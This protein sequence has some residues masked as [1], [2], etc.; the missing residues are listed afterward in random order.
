MAKDPK[1]KRSSQKKG[2]EFAE[3]YQDDVEFDE[4]D[5]VE[6]EDAELLD[7][8]DVTEWDDEDDT[9]FEQSRSRQKDRRED[10]PPPTSKIGKLRERMRPHPVRPGEQDPLQSPL[11]LGLFGGTLLLLLVG[12]ILWFIIGRQSSQKA[13]DAAQEKLDTGQYAQ[14]IQ[15]FE[16]FQNDYPTH[17]LLPQARISQ[18]KA[19]LL[20]YITGGSPDWPKGLEELQN[21]IRNFKDQEEFDELK[22]DLRRYAT[23]IAVGSA[24]TA[25]QARERS[26]LTIP[27]QALVIAQRYT[28]EEAEADELEEEIDRLLIVANA[29][30]VKQETYDAA[31]AKIEKALSETP[32]RTL[33]GMHTREGLLARYPD[34]ETNPKIRLLLRQTLNAEKALVKSEQRDLAVTEED[35]PKLPQPPVTLITHSSTRSDVA[36]RNNTIF[37]LAKGCLFGADA[38]TG[39]PVWRR[40][41]GLDTPFF[42]QRI[43]TKSPG[44]LIFDTNYR[45]L[46]ALSER[47]GGLLWRLP[48]NDQLTGAPLEH[49]NFLYF[50]STTN[51]LYKIDLETGSPVGVLRFSQ[52][53]LAPALPAPDGNH[54]IAVGNQEMVYTIDARNFECVT[55]SHVGH[56]RGT[57]TVDAPLIDMGSLILLPENDR[58]DSCLL[59]V[60]RMGEPEEQIVEV[61]THRIKGQVR[62][63]PVLRGNQLYVP[64]SGERFTVFTVSD[65]PNLDS[66][67]DKNALTQL[68]TQRL[69]TPHE[70]PMHMLAL[71]GQVWLATSALR[72]MENNSGT[73]NIVG[74]PMAVGVSSQPIQQRG[75]NLYVARH[76]PYSS[77]SL[78]IQFQIDTLRT[79]WGL[80]MGAK[81]LAASGN[82]DVF[83]AVNEDGHVYR[84]TPSD[85]SASMA[86][87]QFKTSPRETLNLPKDLQS[88]LGGITLADG[89]LFIYA[90]GDEPKAWFITPNGQLGRGLSIPGVL[91]T[92]PLSLGEGVILPLD[93]RLHYLPIKSNGRR[94][95]DYTRKLKVNPDNSQR[96]P[97]WI[98]LAAS[99]E[100]EILAVDSSGVLTRIQLR[101]DPSPHLFE[102]RKLQLD[103][104]IKV[105][106]A[107]FSG[108]L[109]FADASRQLHVMD[110]Q[111]FQILGSAKLN[112]DATNAVW[113]VEGKVF[114]E[115]NRSEL[116]AF[117]ITPTPKKLWSLPLAGSGLAGSPMALNGN[118]VVAKQNGEILIVDPKTGEAPVSHFLG[119]ALVDPPLM[120]G[121]H[122]LAP[123]LDGSLYPLEPLLK[124]TP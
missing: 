116:Q 34:V 96:P 120:F 10:S 77:S 60:F 21:F 115:S 121:T 39:E 99:G 70:G 47:T 90:G 41:V 114:V 30:I 6:E 109:A 63:T 43:N 98:H 22:P 66:D 26:L 13:F 104:P 54:L 106:F 5:F 28:P 45:E 93:N 124:S 97:Q 62:D 64:S 46:L 25:A 49:E 58:S 33:D 113:M 80:T 65:D 87:A 85:F 38:T 23:E 52:N 42:P 35:H 100:N 101:T 88:P 37:G 3:L 56:K 57:A 2:E 1:S 105:P 44:I 118:L 91:Q 119:Q 18:G 9:E 122:L 72:R 74:E 117:E 19:T 11:V 36:S 7:E 110:A 89:S 61:E 79:N 51:R 40:S 15:L 29:A 92:K 12:G 111:S 67:P 8:D 103:S 14:A 102:S 107:A 17:K 59:R 31:V 94:V 27:P 24:K 78:M 123:S 82:G 4:E 76:R 16:K 84:L 69:P 81:I 73:T 95:D 112:G 71:E 53:L 86:S 83:V 48:L 75:D 108:I 50:A 68:S 32:P 55:V 20:Q